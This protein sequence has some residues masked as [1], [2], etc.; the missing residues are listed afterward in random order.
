MSLL[1]IFSYLEAD[2]VFIAMKD[3][4]L[5]EEAVRA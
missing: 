2:G 4:R 1:R 5:S 3:L